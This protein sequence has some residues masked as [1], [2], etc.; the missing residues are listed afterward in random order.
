MNGHNTLT[1][2]CRFQI[3]FIFVGS[4]FISYIKAKMFYH[5]NGHNTLTEICRFQIHF[6]YQSQNVLSY[7]WSQHTYRDL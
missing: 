6:I 5:M 1:E 2:I 4:R 3:H 7:E